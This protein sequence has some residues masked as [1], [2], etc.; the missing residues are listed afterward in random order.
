MN[1][2]AA[3]GKNPVTHIG[4]LYNIVAQQIADTLV[5]EVDG[6]SD[7]YCY[8]LSQIGSPISQ[9]KVIDIKVKLVNGTS[10]EEIKIEDVVND[11]LSQIHKIQQELLT[12]RLHV[13]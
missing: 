9:P 6:I 7:T 11:K 1:M 5:T 10:I 3:A 12:R 4:K 2:E 8:L 13:Y